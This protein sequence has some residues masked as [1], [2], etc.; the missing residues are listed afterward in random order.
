MHPAQPELLTVAGAGAAARASTSRAAADAG[1]QRG[2]EGLMTA[3]RILQR[4]D[5]RHRR[6]QAY[7]CLQPVQHR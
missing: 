5:N 7:G 1:L 6:A 4:Q 2:S 3:T